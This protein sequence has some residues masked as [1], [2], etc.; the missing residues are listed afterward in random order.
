MIYIH[1]SILKV[2]ADDLMASNDGVSLHECLK[3]AIAESE[4]LD[5]ELA[6]LLEETKNKEAKLEALK[7]KNPANN[8]SSSAWKGYVWAKSKAEIIDKA[9]VS[10][11]TCSTFQC[12]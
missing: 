7:L 3:Q 12:N 8:H 6:Q 9:D 11:D 5:R 10:F 1:D 2:A 4:S